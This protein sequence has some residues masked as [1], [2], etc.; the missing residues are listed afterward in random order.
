MSPKC[1]QL[2]EAVYS[3]GHCTVTVTCAL[4]PAFQEANEAGYFQ[5]SIGRGDVR[6]VYVNQ[7]G[8]QAI[9]V[10]EAA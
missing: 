2:L 8:E 10:S 3:A 1:R 7:K 9:G 5:H 4:N 6:Y